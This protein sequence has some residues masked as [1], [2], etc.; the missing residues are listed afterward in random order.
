M[1]RILILILANSLLAPL[2]IADQNKLGNSK[3]KEEG[4]ERLEGT[5]RFKVGCRHII[6]SD[7]RMTVW[8][9]TFLTNEEIG[10]RYQDKTV[11]V[12]RGDKTVLLGTGE[13][14][15]VWRNCRR[16]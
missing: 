12:N 7:D 10:L 1:S 4:Y 14:I 9:P 3:L 8:Y 2:A 13:K 11:S 6:R 5:N 16:L 15:T